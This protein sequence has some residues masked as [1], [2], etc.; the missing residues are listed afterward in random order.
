MRSD[1]SLKTFPHLTRFF[2]INIVT[3]SS[4]AK[5]LHEDLVEKFKTFVQD[6]VHIKICINKRKQYKNINKTY[7]TSVSCSLL[8]PN[9][10]N[11]LLNW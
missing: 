5:C 8:I 6:F 9:V 1:F 2:P 10:K 3:K 4:T 7:S 11:E